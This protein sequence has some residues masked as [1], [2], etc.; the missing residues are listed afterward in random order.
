MDKDLVLAISQKGGVGKSTWTRGFVETLRL[1]GARVAAYDADGAVGQLFQYLGERMD[2]VKLSVQDP[3]TGVACFDVRE[4]R[5]RGR[6]VNILD[7]EADLAVVDLPGGSFG[8]VAEVLGDTRKIVETFQ[9]AGYRIHVVLVITQVKAGVHAVYECIQKFGPDVHYVVVRNLAFAAPE[10]FVVFDGYI[11]RE[12]GVPERGFLRYGKA[13]EMLFEV[14]GEVINLPKINART[15]GLLDNE[16]ISFTRGM[17]RESGMPVQQ[18]EHCRIFL[19][20]F[21]AEV[22]KS[23]LGSLYPTAASVIDPVAARA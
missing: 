21:R 4:E 5:Q 3:H 18:R 11:D 1:D 19:N 20:E 16:D 14:G 8:A 13:K 6:L 10:D 7:E 22:M 9:A 15:Y 17:S 2:G 23:K 12:K